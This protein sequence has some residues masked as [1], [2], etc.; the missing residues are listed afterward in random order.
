MVRGVYEL[1][2]KLLDY[3]EGPMKISYG[4]QPD[5][6]DPTV[7]DENGGLRK[8]ESYES[9]NE[10]FCESRRSIHRT[11]RIVAR[12]NSIQTLCNRGRV[13]K[14]PEMHNLYLNFLKNRC[15]Y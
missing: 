13:A 9:R 5:S 10:G 3:W 7:R 14:P 8:R 6:G 2:F 1:A 11:L 12:L 4:R 15:W